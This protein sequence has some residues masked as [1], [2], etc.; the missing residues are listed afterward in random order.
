[1]N[2]LSF[3]LW[4]DRTIHS[5]VTCYMLYEM[6]LRK[7]KNQSCQSKKASLHLVNALE[8]LCD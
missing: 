7:A 8:S 4:A 3:G 5:F 1:M 6:N 2:S